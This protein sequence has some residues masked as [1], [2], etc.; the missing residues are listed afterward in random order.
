MK[1]VTLSLLLVAVAM[2]WSTSA[3]ALSGVCSNCHTMHNSQDGSAV[4]ATGP[5]A[6]LLN[7]SCVSCH[8]GATAAT[9]IPKVDL[10]A[11]Q[12]AAPLA[13]GSFSFMSLGESYGHN[14]AG[15]A[16]PAA[17]VALGNTPPGGTALASQLTCA[18]TMGCHGDTTVADPLASLAGAHHGNVLLTDLNQP[19]SAAAAVADSYRFLKGIKGIEDADYEFTSSSS[20]HNQYYGTD[21]VVDP[22][23]ISSLCASCHTDFHGSAGAGTGATAWIRHPTDF[24]LN[25]AAGAEYNGYATYN[26]L[27]PVA[28]DVSG[29]VSTTV[30]TAGNG[31]VNCLSCHRAHAS[32][33]PDA[34]RFAYNTMTAGT[35]G[36]TGCFVCH[37]TK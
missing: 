12:E 32:D 35:G 17:D 9:G 5:N 24:D 34:L 2:L 18:G 22:Q 23:T 26:P 1:K 27:V 21:E 6:V 25:S 20:D 36:T 4:D 37:S 15:I 3:F 31:I 11:G 33:Q 10:S 19:A 14:V 16:T 29:V 7:D 8:T 28:N 30:Q 13:G